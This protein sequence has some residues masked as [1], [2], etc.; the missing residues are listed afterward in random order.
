MLLWTAKQRSDGV[1]DI[2]LARRWNSEERS[3]YEHKGEQTL[4]I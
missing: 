4:G 3:E 2:G 1:H